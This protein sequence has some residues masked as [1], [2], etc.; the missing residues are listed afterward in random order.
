MRLVLYADTSLILWSAGAPYAVWYSIQASIPIIYGD[1][2]GF[3]ALQ[4]SLC[5]LS[6]GIG[7]IAGGLIAGRLMD[8]NYKVV[9]RNHNLPLERRSGD[10][11]PEFPIEEAR[12][13]GC[14]ILNIFSVGDLAS[15]WW[16]VHRHVHPS[17]PLVLQFFNG[18]KCTIVLQIFSTLV[19]D[20]FPGQ[21][22]AAGAAKNIMRCLLSAALV[23]VLQPLDNSI[24]KGW[25]FTLIRLVDALN[26][27]IVVWLLRHNGMRWR[28]S[29]EA[30]S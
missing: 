13:R 11:I 28:A 26:N 7:V 17:V 19:I 9:A 24:G 2:Y 20:I 8:Y 21:S 6:G 1:R 12:S 15:Y 30:S 16:V 22:G 18:A 25:M 29:R 4:V 14:C 27:M 5:Y 10:D 3:K 23:A